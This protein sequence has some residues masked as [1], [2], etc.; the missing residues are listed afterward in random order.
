MG[1]LYFKLVTRVYCN[2]VSSYMF[3]KAKDLFSI[4]KNALNYNIGAI[5][6]HETGKVKKD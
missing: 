4:L 2:L 3:L 6:S 5:L 1:I